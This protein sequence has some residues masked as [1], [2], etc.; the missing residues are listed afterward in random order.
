M[1]ARGARRALNKPQNRTNRTNERRYRTRKSERH[2]HATRRAW[3][4]TIPQQEQQPFR[5]VDVTV[6]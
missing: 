1:H 2:A 4:A 6:R 3:H 5:K